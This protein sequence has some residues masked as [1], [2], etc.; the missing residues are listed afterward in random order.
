[1]GEFL[2][3]LSQQ[4]RY[5]L[6][7]V[8]LGIALEGAALYYQ[9]VRDEW[10]CVLCIQ[11]RIWVVAFTLLGLLAI[12][13]TGFKV[14]MKVFHGISVVIMFGLLERSWRVLA[15][16]RGWIFGDCEMDLGMPAWFALDKWF[17]WIFEVQTSC[18]YTPLILFDI[19]LAEVLLVFSVFLSIISAALFVASWFDNYS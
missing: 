14:A 6:F 1:M 8:L 16:E 12:F 11:V 3:N 13:F 7:L 19:S 5:W 17:P 18:G 9:Y 10:P 2:V 4:R 15:V